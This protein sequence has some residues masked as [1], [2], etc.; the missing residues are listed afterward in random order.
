VA[1]KKHRPPVAGEHVIA[2]NRRARYDYE[3][4][5]TF[6]AGLALVGTE[7]KSLRD[8]RVTLGEGFIIIKNG[9]AWLMGVHIPEYSHGNRNNHEP[10]RPRKLLLRAL[11]IE[12]I[13]R[14]LE[15]QGNT[16]V[17][18]VLYFKNGWVKLEFGLGKGKKHYDKRQAERKKIDR[19][20]SRDQDY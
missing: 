18:M 13:Q 11:E 8:G 4:E 6:E 16:G 5:S 3:I 14:K 15:E 12:R 20:E 19:R 2:T 17:P 10:R 9:E 1:K 7:V